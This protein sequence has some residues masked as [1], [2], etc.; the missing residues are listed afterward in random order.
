MSMTLV[1]GFSC[2]DGFVIA[3]DDEEGDGVKKTAQKIIGTPMT[4]PAHPYQ[5][6]IA[7]A[8]DS[9]GCQSAA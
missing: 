1:T 6:A 4:T 2:L 5:L 3:V 9:H 7:F 8:G